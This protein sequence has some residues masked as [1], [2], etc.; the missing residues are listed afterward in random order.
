MYDDLNA[1]LADLDTRRLL[2]RVAEPV[3]PVLEIAAVTDRACKSPGGGPALLFEQPTGFDMPVASNLYGSPE[4]M[5][6]ALGVKAL[7]DL[8]A[9]IDEL[10]TPQMPAGLIDA[11]KMLPMVGRLRDLMP[12]TVKDAPCQEVV[13]RDGS[14]DELPILTCWPGDGGPFITFP[15]VFTKDPETGGRNLGTYRMQVFDRRS[16]GMHWQRHKGGAQHYRVAERLGKRLEVAVAL[17]AEPVLPYCAT[18]P[19][20]EQLDEL[21]LAGFLARRRIELVKCVT[22]DLEVPASSQIVLEGYVEPGERRREGPFGDHTGLYSQPDDFPVFHLTC[23]TRRKKPVYLTT[24][25]GVPPMEDYY[26][27]LA[28]ERIFLPILRKTLPEVVDMHFPAEGIFH[29][30]VIVSI[31]KR[32]PGHARK[33]M[34]AFWG[35]G[36]LMFSK[37]IVVVDRDVDVQNLS[38]VAWIVGTHMDPMRDLEITRGPVD[39][40][41]DAAEIPAYGG[42]M[43]IDATRKWTSEGYTRSWPARVATTEAA[44]SRA[45]GIWKRLGT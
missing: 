20:P 2:A 18:A 26:L 21:L 35:L 11:L 17:G 9:E 6:L 8:A 40:L 7:D 15:L 37:T 44:G 36:Q 43:G 24:V 32:Y 34:H 41:D 12:K 22:I 14:L 42:K 25:V 31:D 13:R 38:Q 16:T 28:S 3:S 4:R 5:C 1:F 27:G 10:M 39:D 45:A 19:M 30:L 33:I 23:I 29:N